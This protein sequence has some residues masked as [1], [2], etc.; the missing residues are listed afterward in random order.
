MNEKGLAGILV[1][2]ILLSVLTSV[3]VMYHVHGVPGYCKNAERKMLEDFLSGMKE[4][5]A[6]QRNVIGS[7]VSAGVRLETQYPYPTIPFFITPSYATA[8]YTTYDISVTVENITSDEVQIPSSITLRGKALVANFRPVFT[9]PITSFLELGIL[10]TEGAY[11][12]GSPVSNGE[13]FLPFFDG[14]PSMQ[15]FPSSAGGRG[16]MIKPQS[17][18]NITIKIDGTRLPRT[19]WEEYSRVTGYK[20]D[21]RTVGGEA[22]VTITLP[23]DTGFLLRSGVA[24]FITGK[25]VS[26]ANY[27]IPTAPTVQKSP[28]AV[29]VE[30]IDEYFNPVKSRIT[31]S[32]VSGSSNYRI[33]IPTSSGLNQVSL[34]YQVTD[35]ELSTLVVV[36]SGVSVFKASIQ[37]AGGPYEVA[38]AVSS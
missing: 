32:F 27:L 8:S 25:I 11:I 24:S 17:G 4:L 21:Y 1:A 3:Y 35:S 37:R 6:K 9:A 15:L 31:L 36:S 12:D 22:R 13:I 30:A 18:K 14:S 16:I 20:V 29:T 19:V 28:A 2:S 34:P 26:E 38:F 10:A 7:G 33:Y 5:A 23:R